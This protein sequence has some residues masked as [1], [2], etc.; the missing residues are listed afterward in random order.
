MHHQF[1]I[2][3]DTNY[4]S[5]Q[6]SSDTF[7]LVEDYVDTVDN[8]QLPNSYIHVDEQWDNAHFLLRMTHEQSLTHDG[9]NSLCEAVQDFT[10]RVCEKVEQRVEVKLRNTDIDESTIRDILSDCKPGD[11]FEGLKSRHNREKYYQLH[12]NYMVLPYGTTYVCIYCM[13]FFTNLFQAYI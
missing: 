12:F 13:I 11:L 3:A 5:V 1:N 8:E 2:I 9:V 6:E 10:D 4:S 7:Q